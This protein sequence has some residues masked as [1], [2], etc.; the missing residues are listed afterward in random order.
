MVLHIDSLVPNIAVL[1]PEAITEEEE[2]AQ[3]GRDAIKADSNDGGDKVEDCVNRQGKSE[4][5]RIAH[6]AAIMTKG[7]PPKLVEPVPFSPA[8]PQFSLNSGP[9]TWEDLMAEGICLGE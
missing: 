6:I 7:P 8:L 2:S 4:Q 1:K 9:Q 3:S 5:E